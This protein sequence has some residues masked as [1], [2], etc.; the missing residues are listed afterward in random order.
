M[1]L[2][3][4]FLKLLFLAVIVENLKT[5]NV[6]GPVLSLGPDENQTKV[7]FIACI[8]LL[9]SILYK[10]IPLQFQMALIAADMAANPYGH[11]DIYNILDKPVTEKKVQEK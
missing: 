8:L 3:L 6:P 10:C 5:V 9:W 1:F 11:S 7:C 2:Y 4:F